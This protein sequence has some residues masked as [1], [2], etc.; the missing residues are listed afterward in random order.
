MKKDSP[1]SCLI[2]VVDSRPCRVEAN[3]RVTHDLTHLYHPFMVDNKKHYGF[4]PGLLGQD[5]SLTKNLLKLIEDDPFLGERFDSLA[6]PI[7]LGKV[8]MNRAHSFEHINHPSPSP[9]VEDFHPKGVYRYYH[10]H[11]NLSVGK[12]S[13]LSVK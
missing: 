5:G 8:I 6:T 1:G 10:P 12:T 2:K 3:I 11:L 9:H 13:P 4:K 7:D